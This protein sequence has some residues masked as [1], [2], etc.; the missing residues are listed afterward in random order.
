MKAVLI[1]EGLNDEKQIKSAFNNSE[2][3]I[4]LITEGTKMNR[5]IQAEIENYQ[6][7]GIGVYILSDPDEAGNRLAE[8]IQEHYPDI[9]RLNVDLNECGYYTGK[10]TK[11]GIEYSSHGYL[12]ELI[13]PLIGETYERKKYP[14]NWD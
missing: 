3:I 2:N 12:K 6:R 8:M 10:K 4:T 11:A 1:V 7:K 9:P 13:C 5:Y 14:I